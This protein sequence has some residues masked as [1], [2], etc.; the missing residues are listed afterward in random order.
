MIAG[1]V[2]LGLIGGSFAKSIKTKTNHSV[3]GFDIDKSI[4]YQALEN[5]IIDGVLND[6]KLKT[7]DIILIALYPDATIEFLK[8][9]A[10]YISI[11]TCVID[12]CGIKRE[13]CNVG[14]DTSEKYGFKFIGGHPMAGKEK[15]GYL[16]SSSDLY[17]NASM[18]LA[19]IDIRQ[20]PHIADNLEIDNI[21]RFIK[22][23][24][25]DIGFSRIQISTP[26]F[27][28]EIIACTSQLAHIV[29]SAYVKIPTAQK[30][31]GFSA[32]SFSDM[33]RVAEM[34]DK[35][36]TQLFMK[37]R[38]FL[39]EQID[40]LLENLKD[41]RAALDIGDIGSLKELIQQGTAIKASFDERINKNE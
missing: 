40:F 12:L 2:G 30:F 15:S 28:D 26:E 22:D 23:F 29:S 7:C 18:I 4:T 19:P 14:K 21:P 39:L 1:I 3:L 35:I 8:E 11:K 16:A 20:S 31:K 17:E 13:I 10:S 25:L 5:G 38:D 9:K 34:N 33:I 41:Y 32:G 36:W 24:F 6:D 37:N 27:H